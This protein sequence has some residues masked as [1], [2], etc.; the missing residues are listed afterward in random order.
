MF[1]FMRVGQAGL[2]VGEFRA[3]GLDVV[4]AQSWGKV[5]GLRAVGKRLGV[6][7]STVRSYVKAARP[8]ELENSNM[9]R[10]KQQEAAKA[11]GIAM[12]C[13]G[14]TRQEVAATLEVNRVTLWRWSRGVPGLVKQAKAHAT[15][16]GRKELRRRAR[17]LLCAGVGTMA[18]AAELGVSPKTIVNWKELEGLG[19]RKQAKYAREVRERA[20]AMKVEGMSN[21]E[22]SE[23]LEVPF[24]TVVAWFKQAA[25][26]T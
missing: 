11:K 22:I 21:A 15:R 23:S 13:D 9:L 16:E 6:A 3:M 1:S 7:P 25:I 10:E 18:V 8:G 24:N 19:K 17:E 20:V 5:G 4:A 12:L 26:K 14:A 2:T